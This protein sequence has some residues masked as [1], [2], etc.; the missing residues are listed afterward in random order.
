MYGNIMEL[1]NIIEIAEDKIFA[2][3]CVRYYLETDET[4]K[5]EIF[6]QIQ[7]MF[8]KLNNKQ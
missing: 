5:L 1:K 6:N 8:K 7:E 3:L 4:K 2:D